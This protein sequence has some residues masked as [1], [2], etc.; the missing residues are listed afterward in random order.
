MPH[1][2]DD[3]LELQLKETGLDRLL[4]RLAQYVRTDTIFGQP[5]EREDVTVIPVARA[6]L[7]FGGGGG[8]DKTGERGG[9]AG[10]AL[11]IDPAG[12]ILIRK[13]KARF[14]PIVNPM[15]FVPVAIVLGTLAAVL[16][17]GALRSVLAPARR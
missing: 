10:G 3:A 6:R 16:V 9:G 2:D 13:G 12:F 14:K 7:G 15:L 1:H 17:L 4:Q 11:M 5:V 8:S